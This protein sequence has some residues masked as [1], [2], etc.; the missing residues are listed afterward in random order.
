M[1]GKVRVE[2]NSAGAAAILKGPEV[3]AELKRRADAI[4]AAA[5]SDE[6]FTV[7]EAV[8]RNRAGAYVI[9]TSREG[10]KAEAEDRALTRALDAGR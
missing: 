1:A 5:G 2:M 10:R 8:G 7:L 9:T 4:R 6:D 3:Q